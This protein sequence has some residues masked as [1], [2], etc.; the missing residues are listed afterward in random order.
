M[1]NKN[2]IPDIPAEKFAFVGV[3]GRLHDQKFETKQVS[4]WRDA[5]HRFC[6]NKS[7]VVA[8]IIIVCLLLY[9]IFVPVFC[10]TA[11][12]LSLTDTTYLDYTK[13]LPKNKLCVALGL[14]FWDGCNVQTLSENNYNYKRAIGVETGDTIIKEVMEENIAEDGKLT[15]KC[16]VD[17]YVENGFKYMTLTPEQYESIQQWQ[18]ETGVQVI[19][20][21]VNDKKITDANI[22]YKANQ[23]GVAKL[24]KEGNFVN[25]YRTSGRDGDYDSLRVEG[26]PGIEDP[27]HPDIHGM[28][29][30]EE[31]LRA[32]GMEVT[33]LINP[34]HY[35]VKDAC[36]KYDLVLM[37]LK[38]DSGN[39]T[40]GTLRI[41]WDQVMALWRGYLMQHPN[42]V[43]TSFGDPYKLYDYPF[44][45]T[46]INMYSATE[47]S[48]RAFVK[49]LF[50]EIEAAGK[51]PVAFEGF[52]ERGV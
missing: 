10:E 25:I 5:F 30:V 35:D 28:T 29:T 20:P 1:I 44:A 51:S 12:S 41:G 36:E 22:W 4:Y 32:R 9:A 14:D 38:I 46:Y 52:F 21:A 24:D 26:D 6:K 42:L 47:S 8:A 11:Y 15:Y 3:D 34:K 27:E 2:N 23:K 48:Q 37:N 45:A 18:N 31:E 43:F 19:Y 49:A 17:G 7:S 50:G 40:G 13:L 39:Y 16:R 33:T